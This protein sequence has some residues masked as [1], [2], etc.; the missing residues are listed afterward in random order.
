[1]CYL[2]REWRALNRLTHGEYDRKCNF[3]TTSVG[4]GLDV[5]LQ[6]RN[7]EYRNYAMKHLRNATTDLYVTLTKL[8]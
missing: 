8:D 4:A 6:A 1:M 3:A 2:S 7:D 5:A